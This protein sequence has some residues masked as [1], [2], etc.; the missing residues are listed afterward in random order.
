[1]PTQGDAVDPIADLETLDLELIL[2]DVGTL[3]RRIEKIQGQAKA[4]PRDFADQIALAGGAAC[5]SER[6][7]ARTHL[8]RGPRIIPTGRRISIS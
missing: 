4:H 8:R 2:A 5:A 3:D 1:M 6:R 7:S